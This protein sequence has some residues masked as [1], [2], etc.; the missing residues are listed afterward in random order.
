MEILGVTAYILQ[1]LRN[2]IITGEL[3]PGQ[4]LNE[5]KISNEL[6]ISRPPIREALRIL[7]EDNLVVNTPRRGTF[8][9][10][11]SISQCEEICQTREMIECFVVDLLKASNIR[12]LPKVENTLHLS[13][14]FILP[15][16][17]NNPDLLLNNTMFLIDYHQSLVESAGNSR[18]NE[19]YRSISYSLARYQ[20]LYFYSVGSVAHSLDDHEK[21]L[22]LINDGHYDQAK[23][24]LREHIKH[25]K[26]LVMN[27]L[28]IEI[29]AHY[30]T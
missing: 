25:V 11:L 26:E 18:L 15:L 3:R 24:K 19:I 1:S 21:V 17:R 5:N 27:K 13:S 22:Q 20:Y 12:D 16:D 10:E 2:K 29:T 7:E 9:T 14:T 30:R 28:F 23:E 8:V 4:R 6:A